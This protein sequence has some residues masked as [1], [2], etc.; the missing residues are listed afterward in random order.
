M[1]Y[2]MG[3]LVLVKPITDNEKCC[4]GHGNDEMMFDD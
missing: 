3:N 1:K 2:D 4:A